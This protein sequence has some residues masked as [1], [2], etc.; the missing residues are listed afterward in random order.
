VLC[1]AFCHQH[2]PS[3]RG[4]RRRRRTEAVGEP[5]RV[6]V[7]D[8]VR[9]KLRVHLRVPEHPAYEQLVVKAPRPL[10]A[11]LQL[12]VYPGLL[13]VLAYLSKKLS[14]ASADAVSWAHT[15]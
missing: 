9:Y 2:I 15:P 13:P 10:G 4:R 11:R 3:I 1:C 6:L 12:F 14:E 7:E 5:L 8:S